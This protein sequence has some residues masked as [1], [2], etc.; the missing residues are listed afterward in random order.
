MKKLNV[1][2][3]GPVR[4]C[5]K[6][7]DKVFLNI[8]RI[9][10]LFKSYSCVFVESDSVDNSLD[11]LNEY[12]LTNKNIHVITL[13]NL[14]P[15]IQSRTQRIGVA[16][17]VGI[18]YCEDNN[19]LDSHEY[20]IQL[21]VDDVNAEPIYLSGIESCFSYDLNSWD[22]MTAN[23]NTYYD[24]WTLR[25]DGWLNYDCWY[26]LATTHQ[27]YPSYEDAKEFLINSKFIKVPKDSELIEVDSA[28]GG[29]SIY[30]SSIAR[31]CRYKGYNEITNFEE[32]DILEF[33]R[34]IKAKNGKIFI[35]PKLLNMYN[36]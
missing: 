1:V 8:E 32:S 24:L 21:C 29:L 3:V 28:H 17:N 20:Y 23:Q 11:I 14:E 25:K 27:N 5:S 18:Q 6:F 16:R 15:R 30:K 4:N 2:F 7:L 10:G 31:G 36:N 22:G 33:C 12:S 34:N 35:N 19:L 13:G 26:E 9:G